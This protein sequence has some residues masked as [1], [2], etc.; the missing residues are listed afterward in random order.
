LKAF[1]DT[2]IFIYAMELH[3][4][5][6]ETA[7]KILGTVDSG[8]LEGVTSSLVVLEICWYLESRKRLR[9]MQEAIN[10]ITGSKILIEEPNLQDIK[11]AVKDKTEH[12]GIDLNDLINYNVMKRQGLETIYT[13]D[14]HFQRLPGLITTFN[15]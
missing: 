4:A 13:N 1:I 2:N 11:C 14:S 15:E 12:T 3:P 6:S 10:L 7:A 9:E 8:E 5:Y